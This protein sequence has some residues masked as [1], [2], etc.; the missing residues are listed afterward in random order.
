[1]SQQQSPDGLVRPGKRSVR[2]AALTIGI[3]TCLALIQ[4]PIA[5][6]SA[7]VQGRVFTTPSIPGQENVGTPVAGW[8][9]FLYSVTSSG[10]SFTNQTAI[11]DQGGFYS[12][13]V[14]QM[15]GN[16]ATMRIKAVWNQPS[17]GG[18]CRGIFS[19]DFGIWNAGNIE[20][21]SIVVNGA[22]WGRCGA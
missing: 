6:A 10:L 22:G 16:F 14:I 21:P 9:L 15:S 20:A 7:A 19:P 1:M 8:T 2:L 13:P 5:A 17:P 4:A 18:Y 12:F 3:A 11:S